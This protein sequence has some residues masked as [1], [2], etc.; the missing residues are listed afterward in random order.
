[1]GWACMAA[2]GRG[3][4]MCTDDVTVDGSIGTNSDVNRAILSAR[5]RANYAQLI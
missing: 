1:M 4:V 2:R 3:S 5:I